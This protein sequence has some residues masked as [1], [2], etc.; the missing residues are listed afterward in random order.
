MHGEEASDA[1]NARVSTVN[2][3]TLVKAINVASRGAGS[4]GAARE[5]SVDNLRLS[6]L[7]RPLPQGSVRNL[8][9]RV[10]PE[11]DDE[12]DEG[13]DGDR[14]GNGG[15]RG[16]GSGESRGVEVELAE[17]KPTGGEGPRRRRWHVA[18]EDTAE[19]SRGESAS[20]EAGTGTGAGRG[21]E[22]ASR[23]GSDG[24]HR[25]LVHDSSMSETSFKGDST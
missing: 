13:G 14:K 12:D 9:S 3:K 25:M 22:L 19:A 5:D 17:S 4:S 1:V 7:S 10:I 21:T 20:G 18:D 23:V 8:S 2:I 6:G 16:G 24:G 11:A 15:D